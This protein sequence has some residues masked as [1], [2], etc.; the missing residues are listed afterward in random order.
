MA[1]ERRL[2]DTTVAEGDTT[3]APD[4]S[5][6]LG[7]VL[8]ALLAFLFVGNAAGAAVDES[9]TMADERRLMDTTMA[10]SDTTSAAARSGGLGTVLQA[11]LAFLFVGNAAGAAVDESTIMADERRLMET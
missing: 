7:T 4:R 8:L 9:T 2:M 1:D 6:S 3:S 5:G 10:D 11:L